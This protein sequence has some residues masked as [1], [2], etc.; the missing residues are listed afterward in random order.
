MNPTN[1]VN[2]YTPASRGNGFLF[3]V[4]HPD[5]DGPRIFGD[6]R[7]LDELEKEAAASDRIS[8]QGVAL[9]GQIPTF[10]PKTGVQKGT[11]DGFIILGRGIVRDAK[12]LVVLAYHD[13]LNAATDDGDDDDGDD[14]LVQRSTAAPLLSSLRGKS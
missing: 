3:V 10:D 6:P 7:P 9:Q 5:L 2:C 4:E 8:F 12:R 11:R 13:G 1:A 14:S